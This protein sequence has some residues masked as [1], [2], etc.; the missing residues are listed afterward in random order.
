VRGTGSESAP[1]AASPG[2]RISPVGASTAK[3]WYAFEHNARQI[4]N[5]RS[6]VIDHT[7][8]NH[9][10]K[11]FAK[12]PSGIAMEVWKEPD[13]SRWRTSVSPTLPRAPREG[14]LNKMDFNSVMAQ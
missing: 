12:N 3:A 11:H 7:Y 13:F 14:S 10:S 6:R 9:C 4:K 8:R 1:G 5:A 2:P